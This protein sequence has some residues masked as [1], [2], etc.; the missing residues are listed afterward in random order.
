[1]PSKL[2]SPYLAYQTMG[3]RWDP[4]GSVTTVTDR[5]GYGELIQN[6]E[7]TVDY[8]TKKR[9]RVRLPPR[10]FS[11]LVTTGKHPSGSFERYGVLTPWSRTRVLGNLVADQWSDWQFS[12]TPPT[13]GNSGIAAG[14]DNS[15]ASKVLKK[16]KDQTINLGQV[17]GE[18][19]QTANLIAST[20][21]RIAKSISSLKRGN[22]AGAVNQLIPGARPS[23]G[24][25][26]RYNRRHNMSPNDRAS[27]T[28]LELQYGWLPLLSDVHG[29]AE[30]I[31]KA[32]NRQWRQRV[33]VSQEGS[34]AYQ[35]F[36]STGFSDAIA[37]TH[38][39][40]LLYKTKRTYVYLIEN[41]AAK[42]LSEAGI[43]NPAT[44]AWELLPW[45]FV[46]DWFL[47]VGNWL[48][49]IDATA[50]CTFESGVLSYRYRARV[51]TEGQGT[52]RVGIHGA[53][54]YVGQGTSWSQTEECV[55]QALGSF[56]DNPT[57]SFKDPVSYT[58]M[59]NALALLNLA[60]KR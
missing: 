54:T 8:A 23:G 57:P 44:V 6:W 37:L 42:T 21:T 29:G 41:T 56:P 33:T 46:V 32:Q 11:L 43:S 55:R 20:A 27:S 39:Y 5:M 34:Y 2:V 25:Q 36:G 7:N 47:P 53:H 16:I 14:I 49:N 1:M 60:F 59:W 51:D 45:S 10:N 28:W 50:G 12:P 30:F 40:N 19:K 38:T 58:H 3:R 31:A 15:C 9:N 24:M 35:T 13:R 17:F 22:L 4:N 18:R 52:T 26:R 48:N